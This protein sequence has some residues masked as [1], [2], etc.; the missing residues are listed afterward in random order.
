MDKIST[1]QPRF[2]SR[3]PLGRAPL[4]GTQIAQIKDWIDEGAL[5]N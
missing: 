5:D 2:G 4:S 3:M 1:Q